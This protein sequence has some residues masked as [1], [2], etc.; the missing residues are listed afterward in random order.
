VPILTPSPSSRGV[1]SCTTLIDIVSS[2]Y[3]RA[4]RLKPRRRT[5]GIPAERGL[6]DKHYKTFI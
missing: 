6:A 2:F 3:Y 1:P 4:G 5:T